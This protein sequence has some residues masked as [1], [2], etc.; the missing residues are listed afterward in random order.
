LA[1]HVK[2]H[3]YHIN[4]QLGRLVNNSNLRNKLFRLYLYIITAHCL[5]NQLTRRTG[6]EEALYSLAS[7]ATRL[8]VELKPKNIKLLKILASILPRASADNIVGKLED[9]VP[10]FIAL[11]FFYTNNIDL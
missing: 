10:P 9:L 11:C 1:A 4:N 3:L 7:A 2:Y 6:T 5:I 8:F